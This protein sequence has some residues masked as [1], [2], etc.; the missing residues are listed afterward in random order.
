MK[1]RNLR[2]N[3][4]RRGF[5]LV[6]IM[7]VM[8]IIALLIAILVPAVGFV[9]ESARGTQCKSS[10]RQFYIGLTGFADKNRDGK[11]TTGSFDPSR[12][13]CPDAIGWVADMVNAKV[14]KPVELLC[15]SNPA[16]GSE[17]YKDI[18][19][20]PTSATGENAP[21]AKQ[22]IGTCASAL[23]GT[24][25]ADHFLAKGYGTNHMTTWFL[26]RSAP[27]T[28]GSVSGS[29]GTITTT[30]QDKIKGNTGSKGSLKRRTVDTSPV[31]AN[32]IPLM[33]DANVGDVQDRFLDVDLTG[34]DGTVYLTAGSPLVET[35]S[36]GPYNSGNT[37]AGA[38]AFAK[39]GSTQQTILN[40]VGNGTGTAPTVS[41][42][43]NDEQP[44]KGT[45]KQG[46]TFLKHLQDYRDFG[47]VHGGGCN[48][49][50]AD[51]SVKVFQDL[52]GDTFLNPGF[53]VTSSGSGYAINDNTVELPEAEIFSGVL[54]EAFNFSPKGQL[55]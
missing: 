15:P 17:K 37:G 44:P 30:N 10:L 25:V 36:D 55:D 48:I 40:V 34:S 33:G 31:T 52:N 7:V 11:F 19:S 28:V 4:T 1:I 45:V 23:T 21:L 24:N 41:G 12:D 27:Q 29:T 49:V 39:W 6:E 53:L 54:L 9:R 20:T 22:Q 13:G 8:T 32:T 51:G 43:A 5:T 16:Q 14:C 42:I 46:N 26:V 18:L 50:F 47:P 3:K 2:V 38:A 35:S